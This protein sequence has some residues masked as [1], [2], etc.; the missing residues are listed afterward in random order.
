[1]AKKGYRKEVEYKNEKQKECAEVIL[2]IISSTGLSQEEFA[3]KM[4]VCLAS[5]TNCLQPYRNRVPTINM[6]NRIASLSDDPNKY[7]KLLMTKAGYELDF[8]V[9][10][11][12]PTI[13][14]MILDKAI[15]I[16]NEKVILVS[17]VFDILEK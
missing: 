1:M 12:N 4:G 13:K 10:T 2:D 16:G 11:N 9:C 3:K 7:Y 6:L 17:D 15:Q 14:Q 8:T 5:L